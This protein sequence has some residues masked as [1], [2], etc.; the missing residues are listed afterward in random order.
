MRDSHTHIHV[1]EQKKQQKPPPQL[2]RIRRGY[3]R[4]NGFYNYDQ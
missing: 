1:A 2:L 3:C 4:C